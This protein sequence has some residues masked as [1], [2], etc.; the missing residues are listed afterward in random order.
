MHGD[1]ADPYAALTR[2][3]SR[4]HGA[5]TSEQVLAAVAGSVAVSLRVPW[6]R[7]T[8]F[9]DSAA[10]GTAGTGQRAEAP[11]VSG[12]TRSVPSRWSRARAGGSDQ[13]S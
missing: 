12:D 3:A 5:P 11:L 4:A 7:V 10:N 13:V 6:V 1:R 9:G 2:L 8:A